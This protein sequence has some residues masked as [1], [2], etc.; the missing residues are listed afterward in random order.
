M[1]KLFRRISWFFFWRKTRF[2]FKGRIYPDF[3][4]S[5]VEIKYN[6]T[7]EYIDQIERVIVSC[8]PP[9]PFT[10]NSGDEVEIIIKVR[11]TDDEK[12]Q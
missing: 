8:L 5:K 2:S 1:K 9:L 3:D 12:T 11:K 10:F 4:K 6:W 7:P